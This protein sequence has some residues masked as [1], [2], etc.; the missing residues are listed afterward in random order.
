[1]PRTYSLASYRINVVYVPHGTTRANV[2]FRTHCV[3]LS[4]A[5]YKFRQ[6]GNWAP[7]DYVE[8]EGKII[9]AIN[10]RKPLPYLYC[11][12]NT[13]TRTF[14]LHTARHLNEISR[15]NPLHVHWVIATGPIFYRSSSERNIN[16]V[17]RRSKIRPWDT[18]TRNALF[19]SNNGATC[20]L[21]TRYGTAWD[22]IRLFFDHPEWNTIVFFDG[23]SSALSSAR[24]P[25]WIT[26]QK[27]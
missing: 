26:V 21:V 22:I 12:E 18:T 3:D 7:M 17:L 20:A 11:N 16:A 2:L 9:S 27:K 10:T 23:G 24:N 15:K 25:V 19:I 8:I 4:P 6:Y 1:M 5:G 13:T 14:L